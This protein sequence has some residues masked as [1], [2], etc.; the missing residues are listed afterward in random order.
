[1]VPVFAQT[2]LKL[3]ATDL[4]DNN[5]RAGYPY[6]APAPARAR[7]IRRPTEGKSRPLDPLDDG[8]DAHSTADAQRHQCGGFPRAL[9]LIEGGAE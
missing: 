9:E 1:M 8:R 6:V 4:A 2:V 3:S 7:E 5:A